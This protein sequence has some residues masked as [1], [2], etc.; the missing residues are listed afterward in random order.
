M[1]THRLICHPDTPACGVG[2]VDVRWYETGKG[3]LI[4]RCQ[5]QGVAALR[6]PP[7]AGK[8]RADEL[9]QTTCLELFLKDAGGGAYRE[10]NFSPSGRWAAYRFDAYRE[11]MAALDLMTWPE[12]SG[13]SG[14]FT[15]V[16]TAVLDARVLAGAAAAG[17]SAVIEEKDGTKSYW[18]LA[19][20]PGRPD[21]HDPAC[22]ALA[23]PAAAAA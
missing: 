15:F 3:Q 17:L 9:W 14:E 22:F 13:A 16:L 23:L 6:V 10:F 21:F 19:H 8:G 11:G 20:A 4:L 7:F 18:A 2:A 12:V 1:G 5:V